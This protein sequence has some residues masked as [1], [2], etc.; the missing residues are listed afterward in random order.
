MM[1]EKLIPPEFVAL[2]PSNPQDYEPPILSPKILGYT[3]LRTDGLYYRAD[4][5]VTVNREDAAV[6]QARDVCLT[7]KGWGNKAR[8]NWRAVYEEKSS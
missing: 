5:G 1:F 7:S 3:F 4:G 2:I 8:G 6:Y